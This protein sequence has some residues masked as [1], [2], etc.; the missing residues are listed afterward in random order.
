MSQYHFTSWLF[1]VFAETCR[2]IQFVHK[3]NEKAL[4]GN[5]IVRCGVS[6]TMIAIMIHNDWIIVLLIWPFVYWTLV[7]WEINL[8]PFVIMFKISKLNYIGITET[9]LAQN[10]AAVCKEITP[11]GYR[12][13]HYFRTDHRRGWYC[14]FM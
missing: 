4:K 13:F 11:Y 7:L 8:H 9:W 2:T 5:T 3:V 1:M 6:L 12:L 10:D 14:T